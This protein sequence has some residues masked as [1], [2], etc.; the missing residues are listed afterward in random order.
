MKPILSSLA[1]F[2][3]IPSIA[4][5]QITP[6]SSLGA[7]NSVVE[8]NG[9]RDTIKGGAVRDA[10]LF[11]SFQ[12][13]NVDAL[14]SAYFTNPNGI[15]NIFSRVTGNNISDIQGVLG[16]LGNANLY[17]INPNGI[18][19]GENARL[20]VNGSF[21][22]STAD[23]V[24]FSNGFEFSA[25]N[26][27]APPL[28]TINIPIGLRF[29]DNPAPITNRSVA[30]EL[31]LQ[32][33]TG[34]TL[35]LMGGNI[36]FDGGKITADRSNIELG[37]L[38]AT[39]TITIVDSF[40]FSFP[41]GVERANV[42]L[43][44]AAEIDVSSDG[45]GAITINAGDID[46]TGGSQL[47]GGIAEGMGNS[48]SQ[49]GD[50]TINATGAV[51][52][53]EDSSIR[54]R[55][56]TNATGN[57]GNI[58]VTA[59]SV[60]LTG[61]SSFNASTLS[62]G[63]AGLVEIT[64]SDTITIDGEGSRG[65]PSNA[66]S[67]VGS[68][69][70][71]DA[72]G[73]RI[74]TGSLTLTKGGL[75]SAST[76]GRGNAGSVEI[77]ANDTIT[78][79]GEDSLGFPSSA[80][81]QVGSQAVGD[82]GGVRITT[83]SLTLTKGGLVSASTF[84]RGN[85][86]SVE[87]TAR[88][89][90]TFD[91]EDSLGFPSSAT[92][93]VTSQAEGD[94]G[95]VRITTGSLTL[96]KG[97]LVSAST[98]GRGNAGSVEITASDTIT[99]D[100]ETS[101]GFRGGAFSVV[102][103]EAEGDAG[104]VRI[105]TGFLTLT[106]GG[107]VNASTLGRGNAGSV[108]ITA[109]D[110]ITFDGETSGGFPSRVFSV[111]GSGAEGDGGDSIIETERL[112]VRDGGTISVGTL[113]EGQGGKLSVTASESVEVIGSSRD[114]QS[115]SALAS[116][117]EGSGDGGEIIIETER[118]IVREG[119]TISVETSGE[120]RGGNLSINASES[121]EVIGGA[122]G[123]QF[124]SALSSETEGV[125]DGGEIIIETGHLTILD[126]AFISVAART[127][128]KGDGGDLFITASESVEAIGTSTNAR[129][130]FRSSIFASTESDTEGSGGNVTIE[131]QRLS[132][133]DGAGISGGT[134]GSGNSG[135]L[136]VQAT[137]LVEVIGTS[138]DGQLNSNLNATVGPVDEP[139]ATGRGGNLIIETPRLSVRDGAGIS[140]GTFSQGNAGILQIKATETVEVVGTSADSQVPSELSAS[141][142]LD[143]T[144]QG[145][146]LT[147]ETGHLTILDG[148]QVTVSSEGQGNGGNIFLTADN[149]TLDSDSKIS[150]TTFNGVGGNVM[151]QINDN[152]TLRNNSF[153]SAQAFNNANGGN[154]NIDTEFIV[155]FP[156]QNNDIIASAEQGDGGNID[157]TAEAVFGIEE[158]PLNPRTNDI[159]ASSEFGLS[160]TVN[161]TQ[162]DV[163]PTSGLLDLTQ[164]VVNASDLIAQNVCT[165]TANS[166]KYLPMSPRKILNSHGLSK[167][168]V[169]FIKMLFA[170]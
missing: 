94:A 85:A 131:T 124:A 158:R 79:D 137:E 47:I 134:N 64:A 146:D 14:R 86:G 107:I 140:V 61:G 74:T 117:T 143:S 46:L 38:Q 57:S 49:A 54:N 112:I 51:N 106:N 8:T 170:T 26:P 118:L 89:T 163:N 29:R 139:G 44:N 103:P 151:L 68:E 3:L 73:V 105:T 96:T 98:F 34:Q 127:G 2:T 135:E 153:I 21:F 92:S 63:N 83:G 31:G 10:N 101:D 121:V 87:I 162:P 166:R 4:V 142:G 15:A 23:S 116:E 138:A 37:G 144:G 75:V 50:I 9:N 42:S 12:E 72:G 30:N 41:E 84:G 80:T 157:I 132:V 123:G 114:G 119:G 45:D 136:R 90:I 109:S 19:F 55:V 56:N 53:R 104:G 36:T 77:T 76:F 102:N 141:V 35:A 115:A 145:G 99:F 48:N 155:A 71:G 128:S 17:L 65:I 7:E 88:N 1:L 70:E 66:S 165:Q 33:D 27:D 111:V 43:S 39:G 100:G 28:L 52:L 159:N 59:D 154:L 93:Q 149:L 62:R 122:L 69:A 24:L 40:N 22:A 160:G 130:Q 148:A 18:L 78:F 16:V 167:C 147:I 95:G 13:F 169:E 133:R 108:E 152:L 125:G 91:G 161:I 97:G 126:G 20:D 113:G 168:L 82:A 32:V 150:A 110:T 5:A 6:D 156:N 81:S 67:Q 129:G 120:G 25:V 164:E 58:K 11:H 60:T